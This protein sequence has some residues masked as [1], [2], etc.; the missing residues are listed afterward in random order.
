M[1]TIK[2]VVAVLAFAASQAA[3][4]GKIVVLDLQQAILATELA[5]HRQKELAD[6][7]EFNKLRAEA[8]S[9]RAELEALDKK[10]SSE[11]LTWSQD[12]VAAHQESVGVLQRDMQ[13]IIQKVQASQQSMM[14][15]VM[16]SFD[17]HIEGAL[18]NIVQSEGIDMVLRKEVA[19]YAAPALDITFKLADELNKKL[20]ADAKK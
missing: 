17:K 12:Q 8:E 5:Q 9:L 4:A 1:K 14:Q 19:N 16:S 15:A 11:G 18:T 10:A 13:H 2:M 7:A 20:A 3:F 6:S